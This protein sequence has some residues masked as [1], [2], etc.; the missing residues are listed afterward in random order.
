MR[1]KIPHD[2]S[3]IGFADLDFAANMDPPLTTMR[4]KPRE[5]GRLAAE[6]IMDRIDSVV[7]HSDSPTTVKVPA[8]LVSRRSTA[9]TG[10]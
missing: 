9:P 6:L 2:L 1:L 10:R 4:Q 8:E 7:P 3:V 5:I